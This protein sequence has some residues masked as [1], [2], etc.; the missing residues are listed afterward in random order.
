MK[1]EYIKPDWAAPENI[2]CVTT[3]RVGGY[4][5]NEYS[6]LNLGG[7]VKD[8]ISNVEQNRNLILKDLN[9]PSEPVWLEQVHSSRV[10]ELNDRTPKNTVADAAYTQQKGIVCA[11]LTADCLPVVF[12]DLKGQY[13]AVAHGGWRGLVAGVLENT[14]QALPIANEEMMCWLGPAIGPNKF[15][16]GKEV[17]E[18][19]LKKDVMNES[20]FQIQENGKYLADIYQLAKKIL[21]KERVAQVYGGQHCTYTESDKFYSYRRDGE[22]GRMATLIWRE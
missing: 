10:L 5:N 11:V 22:T 7:H 1:L 9:L 6:S 12:C 19:F 4:S 14:L 8:A 20:A 3:T 13:V 2:T 21:A 18:A 15:E 16:V 17:V